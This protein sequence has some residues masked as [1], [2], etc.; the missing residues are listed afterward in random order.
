VVSAAAAWSAS[1][2]S[3]RTLLSLTTTKEMAVTAAGS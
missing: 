3:A 2:S 1:G